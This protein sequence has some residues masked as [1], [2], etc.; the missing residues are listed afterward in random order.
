[1]FLRIL[2]PLEV[3]R[4]PAA[5]L[6]GTRQRAVLVALALWAPAAVPVG[7]L[8]ELLWSEPP[9]AAAS[10][11]Q[12][13]LSH[14]RRAVQPA[15]A[16]IT[17]DPAG[18]R[19]VA[20]D[21]R[22]DSTRFE[23][24]VAVGERAAQEAGAE[25][26]AL[27]ALDAALALWRGPAL[28]EFLE[29][30][31]AGPPAV[32]L[33]EL[34]RRA[35]AGRIRLLLRAG[36]RA[37]VPAEVE[38]W[39]VEDPLDEELWALMTL[40]YARAGRQGEALAAYRRARDVLTGELGIEPG[41]LLRRI[42]QAVLR[43]DP[44]LA[45]AEAAGDAGPGASGAPRATGAPGPAGAPES[46]GS[47]DSPADRAIQL[48]GI[49]RPVSTFIGRRRELAELV[50]LVRDNR[51]VT[52]TGAGGVG[53]TRLA[54]AA[55]VRLTEDS[56]V[57]AP[58]AGEPPGGSRWA[59][60]RERARLGPGGFVDLADVRRPEEVATALARALQVRPGPA[61]EVVARSAQVLAEHAALLVVDN[62]EQV[63]AEVARVAELLLE[64]CA[65]LR[66]LATSRE[67]LGISGEVVWRVPGMLPRAPGDGG[68]A[69]ELFLQRARQGGA[70]LGRG[71]LSAAAQLCR[72]VDGMPLAIELAASRASDGTS[73]A[74]LVEDLDRWLLD[75][76]RRGGH[77][78]QRS[79]RAAIGWSYQLCSPEEQRAL[80]RLA[81]FIGA[82]DLPA[83]TAVVAGPQTNALGVPR[84]LRALTRRSLLGESAGWM[85]MPEVVRL[86]AAAQ[87]SAGG[88][89]TALRRRYALHL[90]VRAQ[91]CA[92][93]LRGRDAPAALG[94]LERL[95]A[96]LAAALEF[97]VASEDATAAIQLATALAP[98]W[99]LRYELVEGLKACQS[100]L[101][102]GGEPAARG[103]LCSAAARLAVNADDFVLAFDLAT[104]ALALAQ[105]AG[106]TRA[107]GVALAQLVEVERVRNAGTSRCEELLAQGAGLLGDPPDPLVAAELSRIGTFV[108]WDRGDLQLARTRAEALRSFAAQLDDVAYLAEADSNLAGVLRD[109]GELGRAGQLYESAEAR[110]RSLG[111]RLEVAH[112]VYCRARLALM[113]GDARECDRL[114]REALAAFAAM[115]DSW[116]TAVCLR[117][118][119]QAALLRGDAR[120]ARR[121]ADQALALL[122]THGFAD[123]LASTLLL[124][125][126][127]CL[128]LGDGVAA[129]A[130]GTE[131]F[132]LTDTDPPNRWAGPVLV[133]LGRIAVR[134]GRVE[135][136]RDRC[137]RG[138]DLCRRAAPA[139]EVALAEAACAEAAGASPP[140]PR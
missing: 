91:R 24:L 96:D 65:G 110:C 14:L 90:L 81:I 136:A 124:H 130:S 25:A 88:E 138:L 37:Q 12:G 139:R 4:V 57:A 48:I 99:E 35:R 17:H 105:L 84:L 16:R 3:D 87:P 59:G 70:R 108:A 13:Y 107:Q 71:E 127:A 140:H 43:Q 86:Y 94:E 55:A 27:A 116:G 36:Q 45:S 100:V 28:G 134:D 76:T 10:T 92:A 46:A 63:V 26:A 19:L 9:A 117:A 11:L 52:C 20:P 34:R 113:R 30:P 61:V 112:V 135:L 128:A 85:R 79:M 82:F 68:D 47:A 6:G 7:R 41:P 78:R 104:E 109:L 22:L 15:G 42:Q 115:A 53:K 98:F 126:Q 29:M 137:A 56:G 58:L 83:A 75:E 5:A 80:R 89:H 120:S 77:S 66:I 119:G 97:L 121:F 73:V 33:G 67:P 40:A 133:L 32:R 125:G 50:E 23:Q 51:L 8:A 131:A 60:M 122:R 114:A 132:R 123:D 69:L 39:L 1:M 38:P 2:G 111:H 93:Q 49:P 64:A 21:L 62:C 95:R 44:W 106:D 54:L 118:R 31:F 18:Y 101:A 102:L 72:R 103:P 129:E 74:A